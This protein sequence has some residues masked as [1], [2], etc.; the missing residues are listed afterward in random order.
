[1]SNCYW[2]ICKIVWGCAKNINIGNGWIRSCGAEWLW[3][4]WHGSKLRKYSASAKSIAEPP[5][6]RPEVTRQCYALL[7]D[8]GMTRTGV[9]TT[10]EQA[11]L[12]PLWGTIW[13]PAWIGEDSPKHWLVR[14]PSPHEG[15]I[16]VRSWTC[17]IYEPSYK[18]DR[19]FLQNGGIHKASLKC[20]CGFLFSEGICPSIYLSWCVFSKRIVQ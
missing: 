10:C 17:F 14:M 15:C 3:H 13:C 12:K 8:C 19:Q 7:H 18:D 5:A 1:M 11:N 4:V 20:I 6:R 9:P 2:V 16:H